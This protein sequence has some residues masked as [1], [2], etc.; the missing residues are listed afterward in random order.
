MPKIV[1]SGGLA[2]IF[3]FTFNSIMLAL[4]TFVIYLGIKIYHFND[5]AQTVELAGFSLEPTGLIVLVFGSILALKAVGGIVGVFVD[6]PLFMNIYSLLLVLALVAQIGTIYH[7]YKYQSDFHEKLSVAIPQAI[8]ETFNSV[9]G[10]K[11]DLNLAYALQSYQQ[12]MECCGWTG[13]PGEYIGKEVPISCC[14]QNFTLSNS[15]E[16]CSK[17]NIEYKAGCNSSR[18][19]N[20]VKTGFNYSADVLIAVQIILVVSACCLARYL[21]AYQ[22]VNTSD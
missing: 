19:V 18:V 22:P 10:S 8:N 20:F 16:T 17:L 11:I 2:K 21:K 15:M 14:N 5:D 1:C 4:A 7:R 3:L 6:H 12:T 9:H 13:L